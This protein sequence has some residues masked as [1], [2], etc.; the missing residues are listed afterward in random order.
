MAEWLPIGPELNPSGEFSALSRLPNGADL[1][2][3]PLEGEAPF[4]TWL[5][6]GTQLSFSVASQLGITGVANASTSFRS[7]T[8]TYDAARYTE[9]GLVNPPLGGLIFGTRWGAGLR[10]HVYVTEFDAKVDVSLANVAAAASVGLVSASYRVDVFGV[11]DASLLKDMPSPGRFDQSTYKQLQ[12]FIEA[13]KNKSQQATNQLVSVPFMIAVDNPTRVFAEPTQRA[14]T[15]LFA[16]RRIAQG[17]TRDV[18]LKSAQDLGIDLF[19]VETI[20]REWA[21]TTE[22]D[23]TPSKSARDE[24]SKWLKKASA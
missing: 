18:A 17:V 8:F 22:L 24:A 6:K 13:V 14:R 1:K 10:A 7:V 11:K 16:M 9:S 20:Y 15:A 5:E 12:A 2:P 23:L 4:G 3:V 19:F 21:G